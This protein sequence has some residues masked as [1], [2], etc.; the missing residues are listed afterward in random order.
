MRR[1]NDSHSTLAA[2]TTDGE[3]NLPALDDSYM[4]TLQASTAETFWNKQLTSGIAQRLKDTRCTTDHIQSRIQREKLDKANPLSSATDKGTGIHSSS[5]V[6]P[7]W[8]IQSSEFEEVDKVIKLNRLDNALRRL[9][10][11]RN[12]D[13]L[14]TVSDFLIKSWPTAADL[15]EER[16]GEMARR[17]TVRS[18]KRGN[19]FYAKPGK[20][21]VLHSRAGQGRHSSPRVH[22]ARR[23]AADGIVVTLGPGASF[24]EAAVKNGTLQRVLHCEHRFRLA[25]RPQQDRPRPHHGR[26]SRGGEPGRL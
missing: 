15:G 21:T 10:H 19:I 1:H 18:S 3:M 22:E 14:K 16:V 26:S 11:V 17:V 20:P 13:E 23:E 5:D 9:P 8:M 24:G 7:D 4:S 25:P 2:E 12:A 6:F